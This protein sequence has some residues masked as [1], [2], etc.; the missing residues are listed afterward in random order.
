MKI[1]IQCCCLLV[2][3]PVSLQAIADNR[4]SIRE[5]GGYRYIESNGLPDHSTGQF[6]N[7]GNPNS[8]S[9][10]NHQFRVTLNPQKSGNATP[11]QL[12]GVAVN[13]V[14]MEPGTAEFWNQDRSS[15]WR[16]QAQ[17][18]GVNLG[19]DQNHAHVQPGGMYHYHGVPTGVIN[20]ASSSLIG[21]AADGFEIHY[22]GNQSKSSWRLKSGTRPSGPGGKY[23]GTYENDFEYV[24]GSGNLD[25]CNG[26]DLNGKYV[27]FITDDYPYIQRCVFG[28]PDSSFAKRGPGPGAP[29]GPDSGRPPE[30]REGMPP[31]PEHGHQHPPPPRR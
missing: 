5:E 27:Y 31:P 22:A 21:W 25:Q 15:G 17:G 19:L 7:S 4:V 16:I 2:L 13:G 14:P 6:P 30:G 3:L 1:H 8:I 23:D 24:A 18:P 26:G 9:A 29:G 12:A 11:V 20:N 10:Q 28:I